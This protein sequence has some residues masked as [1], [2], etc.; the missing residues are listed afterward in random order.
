MLDTKKTLIIIRVVLIAIISIILMKDKFVTIREEPQ[1]EDPWAQYI[2]E[3]R[4]KAPSDFPDSLLSP[5]SPGEAANNIARYAFKESLDLN[6][7]VLWV[8]KM[9]FVN[10]AYIEDDG[11]HVTLDEIGPAL[12]P[13]KYNYWNKF[14]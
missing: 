7:F 8:K 13:R 9:R 1:P 3:P 11:I 10:D 2:T 4:K 6:E 5:K 14:D 12:Y